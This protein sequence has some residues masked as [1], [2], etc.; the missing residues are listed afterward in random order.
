MLLKSIVNL[1]LIIHLNLCQVNSLAMLQTVA[2][3]NADERSGIVEGTKIRILRSGTCVRKRLGSTHWSLKV[4][5][6]LRRLS[7]LPLLP[8][9]A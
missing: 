9:A 3:S 4:A 7:Y 6:G 1:L 8:L 2:Q 5:Q